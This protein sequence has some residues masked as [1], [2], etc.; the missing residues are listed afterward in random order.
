MFRQGGVLKSS[1]AAG[2]STMIIY[3]W[4]NVPACASTPGVSPC[5]QVAVIDSTH[6]YEGT[7]DEPFVSHVTLDPDGDYQ[8]H[9]V[10][11]DMSAYTLANSYTFSPYPA[12]DS[13]NSAG[14][15]VMG[16]G[17]YV[18]Q[19]GDMWQA[20]DDAFVEYWIPPAGCGKI[21]YLPPAFFD[22]YN[23]GAN[24][25]TGTVKGDLSAWF[26]FGRIWYAHHAEPNYFWVGGVGTTAPIDAV[27][28]QVCSGANP[29]PQIFGITMATPYTT[30]S[31]V[32]AGALEAYC[33]T[34]DQTINAVRG[35]TNHE[36]GH[37]FFV[38]PQ[39]SG[40]HDDRCQ[41][42]S[43]GG[44]TCTDVSLPVCNAA[45]DPNA[46]L[47]NPQRERWTT[48]HRF[49]RWD[50]ICGWAVCSGSTPPGCCVTCSLPGDGA[51]RDFA[52]PFQGVS[53]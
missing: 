32:F 22:G 53:P 31:F 44:A 8:L 3:S 18:P 4:A 30:E 12:F 33:A 25:T 37:D 35:T 28:C 19:F 45:D 21:P 15:G 24:C 51:I 43:D 27:N 14:V 48:K 6:P 49:D 10:K 42:S 40:G 39:G 17:E 5:Y 36:M 38:N 9:L 23:V 34:G 16:A 26:R 47:M 20:Y 52:D 1:V 2:A 29:T 41:W 13:G 11:A 50:L 7:H 46:C